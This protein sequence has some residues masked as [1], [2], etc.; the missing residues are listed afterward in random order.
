MKG[1]GRA[2]SF[3]ISCASSRNSRSARSGRVKAP[4]PSA[5]SSWPSQVLQ[6]S[7]KRRCSATIFWLTPA[8]F[9]PCCCQTALGTC[10]R[11]V[12]FPPFSTLFLMR[13]ICQNGRQMGSGGGGSIKL[14]ASLVPTCALP[15]GEF[16]GILC[17]SAD[18]GEPLAPSIAPNPNPKAS[19][20]E[21]SPYGR[22][23]AHTHGAGGFRHR[24]C[25]GM[26]FGAG[27]LRPSVARDELRRRRNLGRN[28]G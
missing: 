4:A 17:L 19:L 25:S 20:A 23:A 21:G 9:M 27:L 8:I 7:T 12:R 3:W 10:S 2:R 15:R 13:R 16:A 6:T 26:Q 22:S 24:S 14:L 11:R 18:S 5:V 1:K 28:R